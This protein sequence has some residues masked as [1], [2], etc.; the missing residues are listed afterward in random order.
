ML[1]QL[2]RLIRGKRDLSTFLTCAILSF[3]LLALPPHV[4]DVGAGIVSG[5][6]LGPFKRMATAAA[7]LGRIR[8]ENSLLRKLAVELM[9]E[10]AALVECGHENDRLRELLSVL[11]TFSEQEHFE[12]L[13]AR[14][15]GMPGGRVVERIEL[16]KGSEDGVRVGMPVVV[17]DGLVGKIARV[18]PA[19]SLVEPLASASFAVSVVVERSRVRGIVRPRYQSVSGLVTWEMDY[20][21]AR[22][23]VVEGDR[24][25]TSGLGGV[26]P[27]GL[28]VGTV[29]SV[30]DGPLTMSVR[31]EPSVDFS[32][33]EQVFVL[34]GTTAG[35][36]TRTEAERR[37]LDEIARLDAERSGN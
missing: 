27:A 29:E 36:R 1:S 10:R 24:V 16:D 37:L 31:V 30:T 20:V 25:T 2:A 4:K 13:P 15:I 6:V 21:P 12:M 32:T 14:V 7:E 17:P 23:D 35:P 18:H 26:F 8:E 34:T 5:V 19:R 3:V 33:V 22:S 9:N 28:V 11:V